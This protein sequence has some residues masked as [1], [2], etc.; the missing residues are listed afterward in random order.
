MPVGGHEAGRKALSRR[1]AHLFALASVPLVLSPAGTRPW[2]PVD[3][4]AMT[5]EANEHPIPGP[6]QPG[7]KGEA[8]PVPEHTEA[9]EDPNAVP[10]TLQNADGEVVGTDVVRAGQPRLVEALDDGSGRVA[11]EWG[12]GVTAFAARE[13]FWAMPSFVELKDM[14]VTIDGKTSSLGDSGLVYYNPAVWLFDR[15]ETAEYDGIGPRAQRFLACEV[16][17]WSMGQQ[18][19]TAD[20]VELGVHQRDRALIDKGAAGVDWAVAVPIDDAGVHILHRECDGKTAPDYGATHHTTQ[21]LESMGRAVYLLAASEYAGDFR[22]KIDSYI[23]RIEVIADRLVAPS[24]WQQWEDAIK[25]EN[26]HDFTHRTFMMAAALGLASTLTDD[27]NDAAKWSE[28]AARIAQRGIE[29]QTENGVNPERGGYDVQY[30]MYGVRLAETYYSTLSPD[31]G[32][33]PELE[34]SIDRAI[35]WMTG[36]IDKRTGQINIGD[37]TRICA[38]TNWWSGKKAEVLYAAETIRAFLLWGQVR[39]DTGLIDDAILLDRG[40]KQFGNECPAESASSSG[41]ASGGS[42]ADA[43]GNDRSFETPIGRLSNRRVLAAA[44]AGLISFLLLGW[45]PLARRSTARRLTVRVGG[46]VVVFVAAVLVL[47]A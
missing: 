17:T 10:V 32:V 16:D 3:R 15:R 43:R 12:D 44:G 37:S 2:S 33:K 40:E 42:A 45:L 47:A 8:Y 39:S 20:L 27:K 21:W 18:T 38:E 13:N 31:S 30:Q 7:F 23:D 24:N 6:I 29:N 46:L 1:L 19:Y 35:E 5:G 9:G 26:G 28:V 11:I 22:R 41:S 25:D 14:T 4:P 34:E 36:R